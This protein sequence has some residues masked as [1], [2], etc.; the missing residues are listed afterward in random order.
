MNPAKLLKNDGTI[1]TQVVNSVRIPDPG[2]AEDDRL[3]LVDEGRVVELVA[4]PAYMAGALDIPAR[5]GGGVVDELA[6]AASSVANERQGFV[7]GAMSASSA[8]LAENGA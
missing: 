5:V 2:I 3:H 4:G 8:V 6:A 7:A 1:V